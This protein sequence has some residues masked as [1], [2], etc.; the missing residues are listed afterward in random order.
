MYTHQSKSK[1]F[2]YETIGNAKVTMK[3][4]LFDGEVMDTD[5]YID[6]TYIVSIAGEDREQFLYRLKMLID[7]YRI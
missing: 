6:D 3:S 1:S 2:T 7:E 5:V 4:D